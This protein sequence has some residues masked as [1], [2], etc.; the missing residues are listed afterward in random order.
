MEGRLSLVEERIPIGKAEVRA[1]FGKANRLIAGCMV[2]DGR[3]TA[4]CF[5]EVMRKR[6][7]VWEGIV[8]SLRRVKEDV[9]AVEQGNECGIGS[10]HFG[11][12]QE[13][14]LISAYDLVQKKRTLEDAA[15]TVEA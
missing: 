10:K 4:D 11:D 6:K 9:K 1:V 12:F 13:G 2:T 8:T 14:D 15:Q 7:K 5:I 3:V